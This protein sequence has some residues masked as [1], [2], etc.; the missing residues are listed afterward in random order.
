MNTLNVSTRVACLATLL[1]AI[2]SL[3]LWATA[4]SNAALKTVYEDRT[5]PAAQL[6]AIKSTLLLDRVALAAAVLD[7][8]PE[9]LKERLAQMDANRAAIARLWKDYSGTVLTTEESR[10]AKDFAASLATLERDGLLPAMAA[11]RQGEIIAAKHLAIGR[12]RTLFRASEPALD[13]M[14]KLQVDVAQ[15]EYTAAV[16]RYDTVRQVSLLALA[17]ALVFG[18]A[19]GVW[20]LRSLTRE[21]G[22]E[23]HQAAALARSV[24]AG[25]LGVHVALRPGDSSSLMA[26]LLHMRDSLADVVGH[27][28]RNAD[29]VATA[30]EQIAQG[31]I[32]L[33][34]RTEEQASALQQTSALME[35]LNATVANNA[36]NARQANV[37]AQGASSV[38]VQGGNAVQQVVQT[39]RDISAASKRI[40][41]ITGVVDGI[42]FQTNILALNAAV[43]AARAGDQG[44]GFAVVASEVRVLARR[45]AEAAREI[46]QLIT[47]SVAQVDDGSALADR[48]GKTMQDAVQAIQRVTTLVGEISTASAEQSGG[49]QQVG[50]AMTQMDEATQQNAALVEESAAAAASLS[51]QA[52]QLVQSVAVF[53]LAEAA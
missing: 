40:A 37:L 6:G 11:L 5:V 42:A 12:V 14:V 27:V 35:Q 16:Q 2:G 9:V 48:A 50:H 23:P 32:D 53:T 26:H 34:S 10:L 51:Q 17:G 31:N 7:P 43:E 45:S 49:V 15:A 18:V 33:S 28:R 30:A 3:G 20:I 4:R 47:A 38:A 41:D 52:G 24:A 39:M 13:A 25:Q 21:L 1:L 8:T 44:R 46:K 19:F 22:G 29:S 36:D